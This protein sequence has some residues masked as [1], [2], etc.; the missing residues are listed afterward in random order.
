MET[1]ETA[2]LIKIKGLESIVLFLQEHYL[3]LIC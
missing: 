3:D 1:G 2:Y